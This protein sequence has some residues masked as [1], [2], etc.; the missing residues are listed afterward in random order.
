MD[1]LELKRTIK[2]AREAV[3]D[4]SDPYKIEAFKVILSNLIAQRS[5]D[6][7]LPEGVVRKAEKMNNIPYAIIMKMP[8]LKNKERIQILLYFSNKS[9]TKEEIKE[10]VSGIGIDEGWWN[11]SNFKRDLMKRRKILIEK[12]DAL[13]ITRYKLSNIGD[14]ITKSLLDKLLKT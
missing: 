3:K 4:E 14:L 10:Q 8:D 7:I 5:I 13:G 12:K 1:A 2:Y 11:G 6:E 9:L